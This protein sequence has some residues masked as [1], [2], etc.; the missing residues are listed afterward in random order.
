MRAALFT[1]RRSRA[2]YREVSMDFVLALLSEGDSCDDFYF[3]DYC[4]RRPVRRMRKVI[5]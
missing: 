2:S 3:E 5:Q 4:C 1:R